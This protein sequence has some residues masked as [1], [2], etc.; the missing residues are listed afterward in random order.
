M[1]SELHNEKAVGF[2][3]VIEKHEENNIDLKRIHQ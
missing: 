1:K 2:C 3:K